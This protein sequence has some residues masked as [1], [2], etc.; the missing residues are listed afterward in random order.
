MRRVMPVESVAHC[1][2]H[3]TQDDARTPGTG[4]FFFV[5][6][7]LYSYGRHYLAAHWLDDD[8]PAPL[9][10]RLLVNE[11]RYSM[12]TG[13]HLD[14]LRQAMPRGLRE[15]AIY[16]P[17][18]GEDTARQLR[19][20]VRARVMPD[21]ATQLVREAADALRDAARRRPGYGPFVSA[22]AK[23]RR[24]RDLAALFATAAGH[25]R[26]V[27]AMPDAIDT[28]AQA[29]EA[30]AILARSDTLRRAGEA[31]ATAQA[32]TADAAGLVDAIGRDADKVA[33]AALAAI[34]RGAAI[35]GD[36]GAMSIYC[37]DHASAL[38]LVTRARL[39]LDTAAGHYKAAKA[40]TPAAMG[41]ARRE[42]D[43]VA[44]EVAAIAWAA[45]LGR[46]VCHLASVQ[47]LECDRRRLAR[48]AAIAKASG[49]G[50]HTI[51]T[52]N[53]TRAARDLAAMGDHIAGRLASALPHLDTAQALAAGTWAGRLA[54][55]CARAGRI[56]KAAAIADKVAEY[57]T[58]A[59]DNATAAARH[60]AALAD[61][62]SGLVSD[63]GP[64]LVA[65]RSADQ[66]RDLAHAARRQARLVMSAREAIAAGPWV[67]ARWPA[68]ADL[69]AIDADALAALDAAAMATSAA[70]TEAA[71]AEARE[72]WISGASNRR[73]SGVYARIVGDVVETSRGASVPLDHACR[74]V[75]VWRRV[76][77]RGGASWPHGAGP[78][79]GFFR[80][81][82]IGADGATIIGCHHFS[83][84]EA[85][86]MAAILADCQACHA[87]TDAT[88]A[89]DLAAMGVA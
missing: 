16:V 15:A 36:L 12:T 66:A 24:L 85:H 17:G 68:L 86:R 37:S 32:R 61:L 3:R 63:L 74:L 77:A 83:A 81:E 72:A 79:V 14:A 59:A 20:Q 57:A 87:D 62:G 5:G 50:W 47:R 69:A 18:M 52:A 27:P 89:A 7:S 42:L 34:H 30:A 8:L 44:G 46:L 65:V 21:W 60:A 54:E 11:N 82:F 88:E 51:R 84:T 4:S 43:K 41:R 53:A 49:L 75:R 55:V 39:D 67:A 23:A 58:D 13:R 31:I 9:G 22:V 35:H 26:E 25:G 73:P 45:H 1:F 10:G 80:A 6:P 19:S 70:H 64:V 78:R 38:G 29:A 56:A 2:I 76:V 40:R 28:Q 48:Q 71:D 33:A